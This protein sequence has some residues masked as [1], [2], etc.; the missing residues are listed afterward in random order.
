MPSNANRRF[1]ERAGDIEVVRGYGSRQAS[2]AESDTH[3]RASRR[4]IAARKTRPVFG[5]AWPLDSFRRPGRAEE[6]E[7]RPAG[8]EA[9]RGFIV[10]ACWSPTRPTASRGQRFETLAV[11]DATWWPPPG[12]SRRRARPGRRRRGERRS[13]ATSWTWSCAVEI[14]AVLAEGRADVALVRAEATLGIAPG[15]TAPAPRDARDPGGWAPPPAGVRRS[16]RRY[17]RW[18]RCS[19]SRPRALTLADARIDQARREGRVD[20]SLFGDL[21]AHGR[22]LF[23]QGVGPSGALGTRAAARFNYVA[24]GAMVM[25]PLINRNEGPGRRGAAER[26]PARKLAARLR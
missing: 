9:C 10:N 2:G 15:R 3:V 25:L 13:N 20:V 24:G 18:S 16:R 22:G 26:R 12:N 1:A 14:G 11:A 4:T 17:R 23:E 21:H 19:R 8:D 7:A 5:I 6:A